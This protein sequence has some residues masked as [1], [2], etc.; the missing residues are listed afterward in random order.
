M[1]GV[2]SFT[3]KIPLFRGEREGEAERPEPQG[4]PFVVLLRRGSSRGFS[5]SRRLRGLIPANLR[6]ENLGRDEIRS[7]RGP[8]SKRTKSAP[9]FRLLVD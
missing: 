1:R 5:T 4:G 2:S 3:A 6:R 9:Y 8:L 7:R